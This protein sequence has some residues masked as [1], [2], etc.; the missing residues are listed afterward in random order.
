MGEIFG[1]LRSAKA[2]T[3]H[4]ENINL[5]ALSWPSSIRSNTSDGMEEN[6]KCYGTMDIP[7][8]KLLEL[9]SATDVTCVGL[10]NA[11]VTDAKND[12]LLLFDKYGNPSF[13]YR[14]KDISLPSSVTITNT[15]EVAMVSGLNKCV[16]VLS[17][18]GDFIKCFRHAE[19]RKPRAIAMTKYG[20][21]IITDV[22]SRKILVF[23][24]KGKFKTFIGNSE[25]KLVCPRYIAVSE[26]GDIIVSDAGAHSII[27]YGAGGDLKCIMGGYGSSDGKLKYPCGVTTDKVGNILVADRGNNRVSLFNPDGIFLCHM[28]TSSNGLIQPEGIALSPNGTIFVT[29]GLQCDIR[30]AAFRVMCQK[31]T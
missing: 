15:G 25:Q 3:N 11:L 24:K 18:D 8:Q 17:T 19:F 28:L 1:F 31:N 27:V 26:N 20:D 4:K 9:E 13:I 7:N 10:G 5:D 29:Y 21:Y 14:N 2:E 22:F 23:N 16:I 30:I 6:K 12:R